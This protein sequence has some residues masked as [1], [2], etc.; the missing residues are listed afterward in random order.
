MTNTIRVAAAQFHVGDDVNK[1]L[2]SCLRMI[3]EAG[4]QKPDLLV[5]PEFSGLGVAAHL[6]AAVE[7]AAAGLGEKYLYCDANTDQTMANP[8]GWEE[9]SASLLICR[10]WTEIDDAVSL[11]GTTA[12]LRRS[13]IPLSP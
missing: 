1:N 8:D 11:R 7:S 5:L 4:V 10:G 13:L 12:V 9:A 2:A 6:I 3:R